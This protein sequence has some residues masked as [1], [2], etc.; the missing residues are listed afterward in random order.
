MRFFGLEGIRFSFY[1]FTVGGGILFAFFLDRQRGGALRG[2]RRIPI[3]ALFI[4]VVGI[5]AS[6]AL[7]NPAEKFH[8]LQYGILGVLLE[9]ARKGVSSFPL[10]G[11]NLFSV[12]GGNSPLMKERIPWI[13]LGGVI[14]FGEEFLQGVTPGRYFE[15]R[16]AGWNFIGVLLGFSM[17]FS[18][19]PPPAPRCP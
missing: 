7:P 15:W 4:L 5:V 1:L 3:R 16:D 19:D 14:G 11:G 2:W 18:R 6:F 10:Q 13:V 12:I 9:R 8:L 17:A